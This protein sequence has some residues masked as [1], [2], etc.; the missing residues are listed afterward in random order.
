MEKSWT[1]LW[2]IMWLVEKDGRDVTFL[3]AHPV[4][5]KFSGNHPL[6]RARAACTSASTDGSPPVFGLGNSSHGHQR[7]SMDSALRVSCIDPV[8]TAQNC[9][10]K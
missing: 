1:K 8:V 2:A 9:T 5:E 7:R 6:K 10:S 3:S 4:Q